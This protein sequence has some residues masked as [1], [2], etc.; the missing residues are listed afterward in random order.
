[1]PPLPLAAGGG[2]GPDV[3]IGR[4]EALALQPA[5]YGTLTVDGVLLLNPGR[6]RVAKVRVGDGGRIA[7]ITGDVRLDIA[8]SLT[9]GRHAAIDSD[10]GLS[11][12]QF[13]IFVAGYDADGARLRPRLAKTAA[14]ARC[15]P[16][17]TG[18]WP[19]PTMFGR[20]GRSPPSTSRR[21]RMSGSNS[22]TN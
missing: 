20:R 6:Y 8:D 4:D 11:A 3:A 5:E 13:R 17:R 18:P 21:A 12:R 22:R 7:A 1:M 16:R 15:L 14:C 19:S 9:V 10:F 2:T